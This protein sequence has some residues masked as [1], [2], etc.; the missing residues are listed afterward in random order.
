MGVRT[1]RD[2]GPKA[3]PASV[4][5][6]SPRG[7]DA[8]PHQFQEPLLN[9][10]GLEGH[11]QIPCL[12]GTERG[13]LVELLAQGGE[14]SLHLWRGHLIGHPA[15]LRRCR[16]LQ[17]TRYVHGEQ[18]VL[19][20]LPLHGADD[21]EVCAQITAAEIDDLEFLGLQ[22]VGALRLGD[23]LMRVEVRLDSFV[24]WVRV[25][26]AESEEHRRHKE[27]LGLY[28]YT[29]CPPLSCPRHIARLR[30]CERPVSTT[31]QAYDL[32]TSAYEV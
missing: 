15:R 14:E 11:P 13:V 18:L 1:K 19:D 31:S 7:L 23:Q 25:L 16:C 17:D 32:M 22:R 9:D 29:H 30:S 27:L 20:G 21:V 8:L 4:T 26:C 28:L 2:A 3:G 6:G 10:G 5:A 24:L 12:V